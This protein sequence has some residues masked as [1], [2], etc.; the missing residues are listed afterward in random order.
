MTPVH[1]LPLGGPPSNT[2]LTNMC[3]GNA[4][5][6][7]TL[8]KLL[9]LPPGGNLPI[10]FR[11]IVNGLFSHET[12]LLQLVAQH[13][14]TIATHVDTWLQ[15]PWCDSWF[16]RAQEDINNFVLPV[17]SWSQIQDTL[18]PLVDPNNTSLIQPST[19][20]WCSSGKALLASIMTKSHIMYSLHS[21]HMSTD[22]CNS[23]LTRKM[24]FSTVPLPYST[25]YQ[26]IDF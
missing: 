24:P 23:I 12:F 26:L 2:V 18:E 5:G 22:A 9:L 17:L 3:T 25:S 1:A 4:H 19:R 20:S 11:M 6:A 14:Q 15:A 16:H 8:S 10:G 7:W 21:V 13:G